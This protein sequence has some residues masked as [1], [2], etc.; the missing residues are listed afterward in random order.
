MSTS[1]SLLAAVVLSFALAATASANTIVFE[2]P[3]LPEGGLGS[4]GSGNAKVTFDTDLLTMR[5]Q[6]TWSGTSGTTT[7]S[8]IHCCTVSQGVGNAGVA[9]QVPS[10]S[11][12][13][14]G[15]TGGTYDQLFDMNLA[16]SWNPTYVTNNGGTT[17]SAFNA[18]LT[19]IQNDR[20]YFNIHTST[21]GGGEIRARL[22]LVPE[23]ATA[24]L[25]GI[26][27]A[28]IARQRRGRC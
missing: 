10:F 1:K 26:G 18:L 6:A 12:F 21:F 15:V 9:T 16:S 25:L 24:V 23:P 13:P 8:H 14:L 19:G 22:A 3:F 28:L 20:G 5:V 27:L 2:A 7:A 17:T 11:G 4:T